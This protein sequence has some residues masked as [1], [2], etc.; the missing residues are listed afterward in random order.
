M[1]VSMMSNKY[2]TNPTSPMGSGRMN[3]MM[4][5]DHQYA[6]T[7]F[8]ADESLLEQ[9]DLDRLAEEFPGKVPENP[10]IKEQTNK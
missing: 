6:A 1:D 4:S 7:N 2:N 8:D 3:H 10:W 9:A 5:A